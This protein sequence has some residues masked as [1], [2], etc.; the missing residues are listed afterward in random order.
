MAKWLALGGLVILCGIFAASETSLFAL[1]PLERLRLKEKKRQGELVESL[2]ARPRR[3]LITLIMGLETV[4]I[5]A[6]VLATS[7]CLSLW[8]PKGKWLALGVIA[9]VFLFLG[10]II[11]KSLALAY[12]SRTARFL[13][14]LVRLAIALFTP[15]RVVF[16]QVSQGILAT[17][18]LRTDL[19]LPA[20]HQEDFVRMV[21]ESHRG[22]VIA[23]LERDFI[24]NLLDFGELRVGQIMVPRPD[25]FSLPLDMPMAQL[26]QAIKRSRFSRI[27]IYQETPDN[28]VGILYAKDLLFLGPGKACEVDIIK[29]LL[30]PPLYVPENKRAFD[31][32]S[33]LQTQHLRLALVVDEYGTLVGLVS[34]E[35]LL[36]ELCG[37]I[38]Q[39]F[40]EEE[41]VWEE[42]GPGVYRFKAYLPLDDF[43]EAME[44][45]FPAEEFDTIGGLVLNLFGELPREGDTISH[46]GLTFQVVRM[47][48]TRILEL[49]VQRE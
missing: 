24:Q 32:L 34:V 8:G 44:V 16:L 43:N 28:I 36:E 37:E 2:L 40:H 21:E 26:I 48:G 45:N 41:K 31:L 3:L 33:E 6:S 19:P 12:P 18:G 10:E 23:A 29:N 38:R 4:S 27:P 30:R 49:T 22:G 42:V 20:V 1:S 7:L 13:A 46:S 17:L 11:P 15:L 5:L 25:I 39:E 9:P 35:D 47:K 14:P